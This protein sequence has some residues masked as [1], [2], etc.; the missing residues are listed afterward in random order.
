MVL[1]QWIR[2]VEGALCPAKGWLEQDCPEDSAVPLDGPQWSFESFACPQNLTGFQHLH[3][4]LAEL[5]FYSMPWL[6]KMFL[7]TKCIFL[8]INPGRIIVCNCTDDTEG[9]DR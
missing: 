7:C 3:C 2:K 9:R 1:R 8:S 4:F 6:K 5:P